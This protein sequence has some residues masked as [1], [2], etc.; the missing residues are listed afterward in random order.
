LAGP[1]APEDLTTGA[2]LAQSRQK[3]A[4]RRRS[5][6]FYVIDTCR[7]DRMCFHRYYKKTTPFLARLAKH[8]VL[9]EACT[10]QA[11]WTKPS[12]AA[13]LRSRYPST[14]GIYKIDQRLPDEVVTWPEVLHANGIYT[15][16]FS[17]NI[18]MGNVLSNFAQ[19]FDHFVES[20]EINQGDPIRFA[21]G[22]A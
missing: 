18:V 4:S 21:S 10:S 8:S 12:M 6:L 19:G 1:S 13:I 3:A 16:G 15:V 7:R 5:V 20:T 9:F 2:P 11:G 14:T 22:S 17:A